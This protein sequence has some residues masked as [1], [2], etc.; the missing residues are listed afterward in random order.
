MN[1]KK[2][3]ADYS[4]ELKVVDKKLLGIFESNVFLIPMVGQ[5]IISGGGKRIRPLFLLLCADLCGY[6]GQNRSLFAAIIEAIHTA[7]LLH[8]DV[9]DGADTRRGRPTAHSIWG[10]QV[11]VLTGDFL[12][13]NA[14]R[15]AVA[16]RNQKIME[17]LSEATTRMTEGEILQLNKIGDP[18]ITEDEYFQIISAKTGVLISAA[19]RIAAILSEQ[20]EE[21]EMA[22]LRFGMKTGIAFQLADDILD[23]VAEQR[24]LG[25]RLGKDLEEGKITMPLIYLLKVVSEH[26][27]DEIR[28]IIKCQR[29]EDKEQA[30]NG[31]NRILELFSK[32]N[33][34]EESLKIA[35]SIIDEARSEL[36]IFPDC[37]ERDALMV[38]AEYAMQRER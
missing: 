22:L 36:D 18:D 34:I 23:Y 38:M 12:Y 28:K 13:S 15:L 1:A 6:K 31:L 5:H 32:Y 26:E 7:S 3:F 8:D 17:T 35:R 4:E 20:S 33:A 11:V 2:I 14:L 25:K 24:D 29:P 16:Q 27:S 10:N 30:N 21:K 37:K 19:C 9:I